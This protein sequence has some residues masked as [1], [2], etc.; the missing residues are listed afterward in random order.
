[1]GDTVPPVSAKLSLL[2]QSINAALVLGVLVSATVLGV[3]GTLEGDALIAIYSAAIGFAGAGG[4]AIG[5]I[6]QA[7]NGKVT[8]S[9]A[10][11]A[12]REMTLRYM[13]QGAAQ[14]EATSVPEPPPLQTEPEP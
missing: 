2:G 5:A 9:P 1:M 4:A 7:V 3:Q 13:A 14:A 12:E 11:L 6:G 10:L 8:V